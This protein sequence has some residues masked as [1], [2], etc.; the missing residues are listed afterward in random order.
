[1]IQVS[2]A[3]DGVAKNCNHV[4]RHR[5]RHVFRGPLECMAIPKENYR[6]FFGCQ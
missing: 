2:K 5:E 1:M 6:S 4:Q 3:A